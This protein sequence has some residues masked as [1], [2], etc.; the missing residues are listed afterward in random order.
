MYR[1]MATPP[2]C[3]PTAW[4]S[5]VPW[6]AAC[7]CRPAA[8]QHQRQGAA[9]SSVSPSARKVCPKLSVVGLPTRVA[10]VSIATIKATAAPAQ[11]DGE[12]RVSQKTGCAQAGRGT[13]RPNPLGT[14]AATSGGTLRRQAEKVT[15]AGSAPRRAA[16]AG[17]R[18]GSR[19]ISAAVGEQRVP[20]RLHRVGAGFA[21]VDSVHLQR[22][23]RAVADAA[24]PAP[25]ALAFWSLRD[26]A[27]TSACS[28][29]RERVDGG[30]R[31]ARC[32]APP[33]DGAAGAC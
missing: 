15:Q 12:H 14:S 30:V 31:G 32:A 24:A 18:A 7:S 2:G 22:V 11:H 21:E 16:T 6:R 27:V 26:A 4:D 23:C 17:A 9:T 10:M 25:A 28:F 29:F 19:R 8:R 20:V 3:R 1:C 33:P 13:T 5:S